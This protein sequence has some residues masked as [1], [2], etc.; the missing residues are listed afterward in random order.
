M[1]KIN[2]SGKHKK[3][4][5]YE[6]LFKKT[7]SFV[8]K[9]ENNIE[10]DHT[11]FDK[12]LLARDCLSNGNK[13]D[14]TYYANNILNGDINVQFQAVNNMAKYAKLLFAIGMSRFY[15]EKDCAT[16]PLN[17]KLLCANIVAFNKFLPEDDKKAIIEQYLAHTN[18]ITPDFIKSE[19]IP[20]SFSD[21]IKYIKLE[22]ND[23]DNEK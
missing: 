7:K 4:F 20:E 17:F 11:D 3:W 15:S 8:L 19:I 1:F 18:G 12:D 6:A 14:Y 21:V 22:N 10:I 5:D 9:E 23:C 16:V 2:D 13:N